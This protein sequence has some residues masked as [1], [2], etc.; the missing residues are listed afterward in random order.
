MSTEAPTVT[1]AEK[2]PPR[3][4]RQLYYELGE[5]LLQRKRYGDAVEAFEAALEEK[6]GTQE[7]PNSLLRHR[8]A[9]A[10]QQSDDKKKAFHAY[11]EAAAEAP[12]TAEEVLPKAHIL[13]TP[14]LARDG[15]E[16]WLQ[17]WLKRLR[18]DA[19]PPPGQASVH[20]LQGRVFLYLKKYPE[21]AAAFRKAAKLSA[22][23][24]EAFEGLGEALWRGD[25]LAKAAEAFERAY[26][27]VK[28]KPDEERRPAIIAKYAQVLAAAGRH[29]DALELI[30]ERPDEDEYTYD[31][32]LTASRCHLALGDAAAALKAASAVTYMPH[33]PAAAP[34]LERA[35]ALI[36]LHRYDEALQ[37]ATTALQIDEQSTDAMFYRA[38]SLI[39]GQFKLDYAVSSVKQYV[40]RVGEEEAS[41]QLSRLA[42]GPRKDDGNLRYCLAQFQ[43]VLGRKEE[44]LREVRAALALGMTGAVA[45]PEAAAQQ[46]RGELLDDRGD[47]EAAAV[48]FYSAGR[49]YARRGDYRLADEQFRK[50]AEAKPNYWSAY[51]YWTD[52]RL[53]L[54]TQ[55]RYP[56]VDASK[57]REVSEVWDK[58]YA[59]NPPMKEYAWAYLI[60]A[61]SLTLRAVVEPGKAKL[62]WEAIVNLEKNLIFEPYNHYGWVYLGR[63]Y[64]N[65]FLESN[66]I[67]NTE[68]A[69]LLAGQDP[70]VLEEH[71]AARA[72][73]GDVDAIAKIKEQREKM[74]SRSARMGVSLAIL[75]CMQNEYDEAIGLL[76]KAID[77]PQAEPWFY[78]I[79][80]RA[81]RLAGRVK[82][83]AEDFNRLLK[84]STSGAT[85]L[86]RDAWAVAF[87]QYGL[88][89]YQEAAKR[90]EEL[91][92]NSKLDSVE[93]RL[94]LT[95]CYLGL[96]QHEKA[97][98]EFDGALGRVRNKRLAQE[99][100]QDLGDLLKRSKGRQSRTRELIGKFTGRLEERGKTLN[101]PYGEEEAT[102]ELNGII[103]GRHCAPG[104][105]R[106]QAA[107][108]GLARIY[109]KTGRSAEAVKIYQLLTKHGQFAEARFGAGRTP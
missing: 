43:R 51:W 80:G 47:S 84:H 8:M 6:E 9:L 103:E 42:S 37:A 13:L 38:Q 105:Y 3:A 106:W 39:E 28:D 26:R 1:T 14:E 24:P 87:A 72:A 96:G 69:L 20:L 45:N 32:L 23:A 92:R 17:A 68:N 10:L 58:G 34:Y 54:A 100:L 12:E 57:L 75:I 15:E 61:V 93:M 74:R 48:D 107:Q 83:A 41:R 33:E 56:F 73:V 79:R 94:R 104:S 62:W 81:Q 50:A 76:D 78:V 66:A 11:L 29:S 97:E 91:S 7:L 90:F 82:E 22:E 21:A 85:L 88:E 16:V 31:V 5:A 55:D 64:R 44:A 101:P 2:R 70:F 109:M 53:H 102:R 95:Y 65:L 36:A 18:L 67:Y 46:L 60:R 77:S 89:Q 19:L 40:A 71:A 35:G 25:S 27:L 4:P 52:C 108:C 86:D 30:K 59:L 49:S 63:C 98:R 99:A